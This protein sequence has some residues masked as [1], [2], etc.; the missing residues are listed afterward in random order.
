M[1]KE[2]RTADSAHIESDDVAA[3]RVRRTGERDM[4]ARKTSIEDL[5]ALRSIELCLN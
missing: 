3:V 2:K 1:F 4:S 5:R